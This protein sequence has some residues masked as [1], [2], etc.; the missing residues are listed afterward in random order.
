MILMS[1]KLLECHYLEK[2][3]LQDHLDLPKSNFWIQLPC[4]TYRY[5]VWRQW[6]KDCIFSRWRTGS[7]FVQVS[8][9]HMWYN[10][11][12][13]AR[14]IWPLARKGCLEKEC[15]LPNM[16]CYMC[17]LIWWLRVTASLTLAGSHRFWMH[18]L[19]WLQDQQ[20]LISTSGT[21]CFPAHAS[22]SLITRLPRSS[23]LHLL[24]HGIMTLP[25]FILSALT[26]K[27]ILASI[28]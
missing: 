4:N 28:P 23:C 8:H 10:A 13:E 11:P 15:C 1:N 7:I 5:Q 12:G 6:H 21:W 9:H 16:Q 19:F 22:N 25:S 24:I 14:L 3:Y 27:C 17:H 26:I 20:I 2:W 18:V